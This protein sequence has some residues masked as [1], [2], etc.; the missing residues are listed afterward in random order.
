MKLT[1]RRLLA[2]ATM[3]ALSIALLGA[4]GGDDDD[5]SSSD[6]ASLDDEGASSD[7][8]PDDTATDGSVS[9]EDREE[10]MLEYAQCMRDHGIDM[11]DPTFDG[12]GG[13]G[14]NL[15][16]TP[17]NEDEIEAAQE[18]CQPILED[19]MGEIEIDPEQEAELREQMLEYAQCMRDHGID[20]PD[21]EFGDDGFVIQQG[22][23]VA[24]DDP[25]FEAADEE[26]RPEEMGPGP[27]AQTNGG[28]TNEDG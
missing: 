12:E 28:S 20:M 8:T 10:A 1:N 4:C 9:P 19:A 5:T 14:I 11:E 16:A 6:V 21:P 27:G 17:E 23:R 18:V 22:P 3:A 25:D 24:E 26:C 2:G 13:G 7:S 15:D